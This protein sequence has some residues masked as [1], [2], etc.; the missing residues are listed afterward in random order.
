MTQSAAIF[1]T[2]LAILAAVC[3]SKCH[4]HEP[5]VT[6]RNL[7]LTAAAEGTAI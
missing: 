3:G 4:A 1:R 2:L 5:R 7:T 6:H